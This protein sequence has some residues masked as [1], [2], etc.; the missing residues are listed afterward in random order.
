MHNGNTPEGIGHL[1]KCFQRE[2]GDLLWKAEYRKKPVF[3][4][5]RM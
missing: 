2:L 3:Y 5:L 1:E 4:Y